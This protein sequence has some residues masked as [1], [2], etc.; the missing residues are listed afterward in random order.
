MLIGFL[1]FGMLC[2][3]TAAATVLMSG[4]GFLLAFA[5]YSVMGSVGLLMMALSGSAFTSASEV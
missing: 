2:G 4:G 5:A 1:A 3:A